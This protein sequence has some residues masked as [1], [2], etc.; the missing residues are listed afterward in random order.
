MSFGDFKTEDDDLFCQFSTIHV[1]KKHKWDRKSNSSNMRGIWSWNDERDWQQ[2]NFATSQEIDAKIKSLHKSSTDTTL[3][4]TLTKG[5]YFAMPRNK[6]VYFV[7]IH[8]NSSRSKIERVYQTNV[9]TG[10]TRNMKREPPYSLTRTLS[11]TNAVM[12]FKFLRSYQ[13]CSLLLL[14]DQAISSAANKKY[15]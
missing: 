6:G 8:L 14:C 2:F 10:K 9:N 5:P 4:F 15:P 7:T 3:S 13:K 11:T 1:S 12:R